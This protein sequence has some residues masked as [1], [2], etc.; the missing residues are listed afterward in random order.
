M[1]LN[2]EQTK[3][4][5]K[6]I[7]QN[8]FGRG[9]SFTIF[10]NQMVVWTNYII[11][12]N[13]KLFIMQIT[14][15]VWHTKQWEKLQLRQWFCETISG[16]AIKVEERKKNKKKSTIWIKLFAI[17]SL[18]DAHRNRTF[19]F[20]IFFCSFSFSFIVL[21]FS[22]FSLCALALFAETLSLICILS[23]AMRGSFWFFYTFAI[24]LII[25][26][27]SFTKDRAAVAAFFHLKRDTKRAGDWE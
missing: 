8:W 15:S 27:D 16:R 3:M 20:S 2:W 18:C 11:K 1:Y 26:I 7:T 19:Y 9:S 25:I 24:E 4:K 12:T 23:I 22:G 6:N 17:L 14:C 13:S 10:L 21:I 5:K